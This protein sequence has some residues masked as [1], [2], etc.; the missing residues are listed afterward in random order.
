VV[1]FFNCV[2]TQWLKKCCDLLPKSNITASEADGWKVMA[3]RILQ[4]GEAAPWFTCRSPANSNFRFNSVAGRYVVL[5]FFDSAANAVSQRILHGVLSHRR[6]FDDK[7]ACFFGVSNDPADEKENRLHNIVPGIRFLWDFDEQVSR[8]FGALSRPSDQSVERCY[9]P[10]TYVLDE[11]LRVLSV[12]RFG[13]DPD[14]HV[15]RI[16]DLLRSRL[17]LLSA[18]VSTSACAPV[19]DVPRVFEPELCR[20]LTD[21]YESNGGRESGYVREENGLTV[22]TSDY[23]HKQRRDQLIHDESLRNAVKY[24]IRNRLIPEIAKAFQFQATRIERYIV[25][26][27]DS[28]TG[29]HFSPHRD[30]LTKGTAHRRFAA[31]INLNNDFEGGDLRFPEFGQQV[32]RPS[33]GGAIVFSCSLLHEAT[34]ITIGKRYACLPFLYDEAAA[35]I[36][37]ANLKYLGDFESFRMPSEASSLRPDRRKATN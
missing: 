23:R 5:C 27:Y 7:N 1:T 37:A 18:V 36:R 16:V 22:E 26:C 3:E 20:T 13:T 21:Y 24:R 2:T 4:I 34:P 25:A 14:L 19:L 12:L 30:N 28:R 11:R 17:D 15:R 29:G 33:T 32:Y 35:E 10:L 31:S 6:L 8:A 9:Q